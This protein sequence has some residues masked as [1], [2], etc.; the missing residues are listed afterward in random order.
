MAAG[1]APEVEAAPPP[2]KV[3]CAGCD[4]EHFEWALF[5]EDWRGHR[6]FRA[7]AAALP[8]RDFPH[9]IAATERLALLHEEWRE[10]EW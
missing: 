6:A 2:Q 5:G 9:S 7:I 3:N 10:E 4:A 1:M 8:R